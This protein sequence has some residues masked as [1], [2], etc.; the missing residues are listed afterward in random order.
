MIN[1]AITKEVAV[2]FILSEFLY[3]SV[4][5]YEGLLLVKMPLNELYQL[6]QEQARIFF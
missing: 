5:Y 6:N 4:D 3:M 2:F 1:T